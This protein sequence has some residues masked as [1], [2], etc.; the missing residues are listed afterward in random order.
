M[1]SSSSSEGDEI[2][3][4]VSLAAAASSSDG[5]AQN[6]GRRGSRPG[7]RRNRERYFDNST[8]RIVDDY[9]LGD[10]SFRQDGGRGK[11]Y[12]EEEF[13]RRFRMPRSVFNMIF[14]VVSLDSY[15][16][17]RPDATGKTGSSARLYRSKSDAK[18]IQ[19][20]EAVS[21]THLTLPTILLV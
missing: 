6:R 13:E 7:R 20:F 2:V 4:V 18:Q 10:A 16:E 14:V 21:Y 9:F 15:F 3:A 8:R 1:S 17:E 12:S 5:A 19:P 11:R